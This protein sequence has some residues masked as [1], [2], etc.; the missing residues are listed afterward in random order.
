V[1][2]TILPF[3]E[4]IRNVDFDTDGG[5]H[6]SSYTFGEDEAVL[7]YE[8]RTH[9]SWTWEYLTLEGI[10]TPGKF[11]EGCVALLAELPDA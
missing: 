10:I 2:S 5:Y 6:Y 1:T 3:D 8:R 11:I 4:D 7:R 9:A